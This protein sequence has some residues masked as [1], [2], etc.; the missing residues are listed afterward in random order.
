MSDESKRETRGG[1]VTRMAQAMYEPGG[2][3]VAPTARGL[4]EVALSELA[5]GDPPLLLDARPV[6][7][8][9]IHCSECGEPYL[10]PEYETVAVWP[11]DTLDKLADYL[12]DG[13]GW[14]LDHSP[15]HPLVCQDCAEDVMCEDCQEWIGEWEPRRG[16]ESEGRRHV[17]GCPSTADSLPSQEPLIGEQV[18]P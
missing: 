18:T 9:S 3:Y 14:R 1:A 10:D 16:S 4:A 6:V 15:G 5:G 8:W 13:D 2:G 11:V 12:G 17:D 7:M